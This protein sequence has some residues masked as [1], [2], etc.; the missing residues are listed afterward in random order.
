MPAFA[1]KSA[2]ALEGFTFPGFEA[3]TEPRFLELL[4]FNV[5]VIRNGKLEQILSIAVTIEV[6]GQENKNK[7]LDQTRQLRNAFLRDIHGIAS[8]QRADGRVLDTNVVKT[9][10]MLVS[11]RMFGPGIVEN[12]LV[13]GLSNRV[14][15]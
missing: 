9:R 3:D 5:P 2:G 12:V 15:Q 4:P 10:L 8:I 7:V 1:E 6:K 13:H 11:T 14:A